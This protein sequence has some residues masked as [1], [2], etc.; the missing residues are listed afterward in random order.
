MSADLR[1]AR[2]PICHKLLG[3][4]LGVLKR[5]CRDC[6]RMWL[7]STDKPTEVA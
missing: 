5:R 1:E 2:C 4:Y 6:K 3:E 7:F